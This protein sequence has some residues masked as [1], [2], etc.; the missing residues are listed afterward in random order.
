[1][2]M[3]PRQHGGQSANCPPL[4]FQDNYSPVI[5]NIAAR[6][7]LLFAPRATRDILIR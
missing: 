1:M 2:M 7:I 5:V 3:L 6:V 4:P